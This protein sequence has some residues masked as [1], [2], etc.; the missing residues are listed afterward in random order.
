MQARDPRALMSAKELWE[1]NPAR[2]EGYALLAQNLLVRNEVSVA[3]PMLMAALMAPEAPPQS[4][5]NMAPLHNQ[6]AYTAL[7]WLGSHVA[8]QQRDRIVDRLRGAIK[9]LQTPPTVEPEPDDTKLSKAAAKRENRNLKRRR[10]KAVR[11]KHR[12]A[13]RRK[14]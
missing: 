4:I 7:S 8:P 12:N 1:Q 5:L 13:K 11:R 9:A 2:G 10:E 3:L 14:R 6:E